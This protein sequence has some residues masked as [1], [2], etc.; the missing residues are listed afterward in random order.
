MNVNELRMS[1]LFVLAFSLVL[2]L[3]PLALAQDT[4]GSNTQDTANTGASATTNTSAGTQTRS[5]Q[6]GQKMK[7]KGVVV[8][9]DADT[10]VVR[11]ANGVDTTVRLTDRTSV[12]TK[13][14]FLRGG[15]NYGVT[16]ILRGLNLEVDGRGNGTGEL[17]AEKVRFNESDLRVARSIDTRVNPVE[18]R[19]ST[20]ETRVN[21]VEQNAQRMSGQID[22]LAAVSN[23]AKGGAKAAQETADAAVAGVNATNER[24]SALDDYVPQE[25]TAI[26]FRVG[27]A[28]LNAQAKAQLDDI[29]TKAASARGYVIEVSG[30]TDTSGSVEANRR[31]SQRRADAVVRYLAENH[32][33]PLR[34]I[35]TPFG[36]GE[37]QAVADNRTRAGR[38]QNRRVEVKI[39]VNR[40]LTTPGPT[41][42]T[43]SGTGAT[44]STATP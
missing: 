13:G 26:N 37:A 38:A 24:I 14:G 1:R 39:L 15:T 9:R 20:T 22:E 44:S 21:Q 35:V 7:I 36:Y 31:L 41:I 28:V 2:A 33:I 43:P 42:T 4:T 25:T 5:A 17:E 12:K 8:R 23:A 29:A 34:R 16:S 32:R 3:A 10:F 27:S 6:S 40:G 30:Y 11:D 18:E 19:V